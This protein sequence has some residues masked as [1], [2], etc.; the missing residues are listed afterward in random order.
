MRTTSSPHKHSEA[1]TLR[2]HAFRAVV[3]IGTA[4]ARMRLIVLFRLALAMAFVAMLGGTAHA[5]DHLGDYLAKVR[6]EELAPGADHFGP[7]E[8]KPALA[9]V[10]A[11]ARTLG[12]VWLN[13]DWVDATGYSGK[14]INILIGMTPEGVII[15]AKLVEH[16]EPIVLIGI[17]ES[18]VRAFIDGYVG[19]NIRD[20]DKLRAK[21]PVDIV[22][23]A[24]VSM[25]VI[26]DSITR[27]ALK[28]SQKLAGGEPEHAAVAG[29]EIDPN[30]GGV[31]DWRTLIG[32]G[33][34]RRLSLGV[35]DV[36]GA[37][38][39]SGNAA[40]AALPEPPGET[41]AENQP[42]IDLY[43]AP[44]SVPAIGKSLLGDAEYANLAA[45]L[46][47]G[48]QAVV[49]AGSGR[50]SWKGSGY[51]RGGIFDRV[52]LTQGDA[53]LRFHDKDYRRVGALAPQDAPHF[54]EIGLFVL[55]PGQSFDAAKPWRV[56]LL[57]QRATG[58]LDKAFV[59]FDLEYRLPDRYLKHSVAA[60]TSLAA[61]TKT[62]GP[63]L[64]IKV[65]RDR[66]V[67]I[68][69]LGVALL[70]LTAIFFFQAWLTLRPTL[71]YRLRLAFLAFTLLWLGWYAH[72]QL[73]I[74]NVFAFS[75]ALFSGA[76][77]WDH[78]LMDP[79]VFMLWTAVA[80]SMLFWGRGAFCGW[81]C[82]FGALQDFVGVAAK[83]LHLPKITPPWGLHERLWPIKYILFLGL[84]GLSM[85]DLAL[86]EQAAEVEPFK[87]AIV[88]H[89]MRDWGFVLFAVLM[90][91]PGLFIER[92][93]CRYVCPLGAAL[94]I[95]GRM[96]MF[97]WLRRHKECGSPCGLCAVE[98]PVN[99]IHPEGH[100][101]PNECIQCLHCQVLY[102]HGRQCP[103]MVQLRLKQDRM[104]AYSGTF[105]V[106][107]RNKT[108]ALHDA[109]PEQPEE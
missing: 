101:N 53:T 48:E 57:V 71:F 44:V 50:Y 3:A 15:G 7:P 45:R 33:S 5:E 58:A 66:A 51:V 24:T 83:V 64:W 81:L 32:D 34:M 59:T 41:G 35:D 97:D 42:F 108:P 19:A 31:E 56:Q 29:P 107:S 9:T 89:F 6:A 67:D 68:G 94:A 23:G 75:G 86:A 30:A 22:S 76:F 1:R 96:R 85:G 79:L 40:A 92:F 80:V 49:I 52:V 4:R 103:H 73:S 12:M 26:G 13:S 47:P 27:S 10:Y 20:I 65:W 46:K 98:C 78:F 21:P 16:H 106:Q 8:G 82:P 38:Q 91:A 87:T 28:V 54:D 77:R 74:V 14:P 2:P 105:S 99:A 88:L 61:A 25:M 72:A 39:R 70:L 63:A 11:G 60:A 93:Y 104:A 62:A 36:S 37:F 102:R 95:P 17:A 69:I 109:L 90:L 84:F 55:P 100:I 43:A 18:K